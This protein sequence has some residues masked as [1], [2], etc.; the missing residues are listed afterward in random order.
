MYLGLCIFENVCDFLIYNFQSK[1]PLRN[2]KEK[3]EDYLDE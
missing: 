1:N 3:R 2:I